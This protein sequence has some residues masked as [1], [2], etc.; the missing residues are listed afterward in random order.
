MRGTSAEKFTS[1]HYLCS[2]RELQDQG[3]PLRN[4]ME[5]VIAFSKVKGRASDIEKQIL[6]MGIDP[7]YPP[8]MDG[9]TEFRALTAKELE[10]ATRG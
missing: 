8:E 5:Q 7:E 9:H 1:R 10:R 3:K 4:Q 6:T 2:S